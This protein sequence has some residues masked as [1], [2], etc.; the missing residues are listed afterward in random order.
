MRLCSYTVKHDKGF[1]SN[2]FWG[3]CTLAACTPNHQGVRLECGDWTVGM[4][5]TNHGNKLLYA[6]EV[7]ERLH[8]VDYFSDPKFQKKKPVINGTWRQR[9]GDNIHCMQNRKWKQLP[10]PY[11]YGK[12]HLKKDTKY[13]YVFIGRRFCYFGEKAVPIPEEFGT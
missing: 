13:P 10:T 1:A 12:A 7:D 2:P 9:C 11:H 3:Y 6:M 8:F 4:E 5:D